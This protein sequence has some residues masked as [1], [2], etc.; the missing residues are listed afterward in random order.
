MFDTLLIMNL[1]LLVS[2]PISFTLLTLRFTSVY[3]EPPPPPPVYLNVTK[4]SDPSPPVCFDPP[5]LF[6]RNLRVI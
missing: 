5:S 2:L 3:F 4:I 1:F 6:I